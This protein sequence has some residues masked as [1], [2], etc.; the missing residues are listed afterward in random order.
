VKKRKNQGD[1]IKFI[2]AGLQLILSQGV[3]EIDK[4]ML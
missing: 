4:S 2:L 1:R 3:P